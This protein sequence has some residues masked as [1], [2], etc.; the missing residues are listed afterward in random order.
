MT[1][2]FVR[3]ETATP[4]NPRTAC[5]VAD[6]GLGARVLTGCTDN[7]ADAE[8]LFGFGNYDA[9]YADHSHQVIHEARRAGF[10]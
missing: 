8:R 7:R 1:K 3:I 5:C 4:T 2:F 10:M 9:V 6:F